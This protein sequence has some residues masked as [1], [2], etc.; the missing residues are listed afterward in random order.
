MFLCY[1]AGISGSGVGSG[2]G[3]GSVFFLP[4]NCDATSLYSST[5]AAT[6][7][8]AAAVAS[9]GATSFFRASPHSVFLALFSRHH[10]RAHA[11]APF[12]LPSAMYPPKR[13]FSGACWRPPANLVRGDSCN[14]LYHNLADCAQRIYCFFPRL[15][16]SSNA[17]FL[18]LSADASRLFTSG[19]SRSTLIS[20]S[21]A[22][23]SAKS[24]S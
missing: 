5:S 20:P 23:H 22:R 24:G 4:L 3:S 11:C 14:I 6:L 2:S 16:P 17:C 7:L 19:P 21:P 12:G 13:S 10:F 15:N 9:V 8:I 1:V 18:G